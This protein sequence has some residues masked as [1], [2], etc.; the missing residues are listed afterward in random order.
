VFDDANS[1][2]PSAEFPLGT[3]VVLLRV[4]DGFQTD[5]DTIRVTVVDTLAPRIIC[6]PPITVRSNSPCGMPADDLLLLPFYLGVSAVDY[7]SHPPVITDDRPTCFPVGTT[8][9]TF[10]ATDDSGNTASCTSSVTVES[11]NLLGAGSGPGSG[12]RTPGGRPR[13][14]SGGRK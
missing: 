4:S 12:R 3:T 11:T 10:T 13:L 5:L 8:Q 7:C 9:V 14:P 6:P 1:P 2:T